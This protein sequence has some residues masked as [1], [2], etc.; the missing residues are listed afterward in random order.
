MLNNQRIV[1]KY[2]VIGLM[3]GT[4]MDGID[5]VDVTISLNEDN[6]WQFQLNNSFLFEFETSIL[7]RLKSA[8]SLSASELTHLS[9]DLGR[10]YGEIVNEF[11]EKFSIDRASIDFVASHGQTIFHQ[12]ENQYTLQIGNGPELSV[13]TNLPSVVDF[14]TKDVALGGSGAPLIPVAD[15]L[16]FSSYADSFL[17][18]G[19]FSNFSFQENNKVYSYDIC[20]VNIVVN[21]IM[22]QLGK[23][24]DKG[25]EFGRTGEVN[26]QLLQKLNALEYYSQPFPKSLGWEWVE[27]FV[28]PLMSIEPSLNSQVR[29]FYEH[30]AIQTSKSVELSKASSTLITGGGA[31]NKFLIER[32]RDL[33]KSEIILPSEK[34]IDYKEAIGFAFLGVLRWRNEVN[35]WSSVTGAKRDSCSGFIVNP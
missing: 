26:V 17:N 22:K 10:Y 32:I 30:I 33:T 24:Y 5:V 27:E 19:G 25:G 11:I 18:L 12:P 14:R 9:A 6:S 28:Y 13:E 16:L 35:V 2:H 8:F 34:I 23:E 4:S 3:S 1:G 31:R 21:D 15:F 7:S 20:P 29:T